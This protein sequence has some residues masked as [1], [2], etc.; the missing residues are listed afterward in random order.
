VHNKSGLYSLKIANVASEV[1]DVWSG[2]LYEELQ[3]ARRVDGLIA[4]SPCIL[5]NA[6]DGRMSVKQQKVC[7]GYQLV[8]YWKWGRNRLQEIAANKYAEDLVISHLCGTRFCCNDAHLWLE[9]KWIN[10][11]RVHCHFCLNNAMNRLEREEGTALFWASGACSHNPK[12][13]D[14]DPEYMLL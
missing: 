8:A 4:N 10:D 6:A 11:E 7:Y 14:L 5:L 12:C 3:K 2:I 1:V 13:G 9:T